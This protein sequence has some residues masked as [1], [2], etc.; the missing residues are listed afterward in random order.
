MHKLQDDAR[1]AYRLRLLDG[2]NK[3]EKLAVEKKIQ[4]AIE[5][6]NVSDKKINDM[7]KYED[8]EKQFVKVDDKYQEVFTDAGELSAKQVPTVSGKKKFFFSVDN[9]K[10]QK[11]FKDFT[12]ER[13]TLL[14]DSTK[15]ILKDS[16]QEAYD[17]GRPARKLAKQ[18]SR[19]VGMNAQQNKGYLSL[20]K[21]LEEKGTKQSVIDKRLKNYKDKAI[22]NRA[23]T[24]AKQ[25]LI[26]ATNMAQEASWKQAED[27]G[28]MPKNAKKQWISIIDD[29]TSDVCKYLH[30]KVVKWSAEFETKWGNFFGPPAHILCRSGIILVF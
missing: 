7:F 29:R 28:L 17:S 30:N 18:I 4:E 24:I 25:E 23:L 26:L 9:L 13:V 12:A 15:E 6:G 2:F 20:Q 3:Y 21:S 22:K 1:N 27:E 14:N 11:I 8:T 10:I 5:S 16:I 19:N